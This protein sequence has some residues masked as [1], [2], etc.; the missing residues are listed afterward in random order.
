MFRLFRTLI[1]IFIAFWVGV[2]YEQSQQV[3][4]CQ[5]RGAHLVDGVCLGDSDV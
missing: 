1:L 2:L 4:K 3:E 5:S